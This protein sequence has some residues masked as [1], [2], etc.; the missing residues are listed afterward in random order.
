M[1]MYLLVSFKFGLIVCKGNRYTLRVITLSKLF[2]SPS[3]KGFTLKGKNEPCGSKF[4]TFRVASFQKGF[5]V[6]EC[7]Q[8]SQKL[9]HLYF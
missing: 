7:K 6:Q 5:V 2:L 3:E 9:S 4:F 8:K 1:Y